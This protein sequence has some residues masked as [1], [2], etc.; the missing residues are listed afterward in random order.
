MGNT[1]TP[2]N[3][4]IIAAYKAADKKCKSLLVNLYGK[5]M[6]TE[7]AAPIGKGISTFEQVCAALKVSARSYAIPAKGSYQQKADAAMRRLKLIA[8]CF[9]DGWVADMADTNQYKYWAWFDIIKDASKLAGFGFSNA[10][11]YC[12][13]TYAYVGSRPNFKS[14][15]ICIYVGKAFVSEF[16][17]FAQ[18]QQLA[19]NEI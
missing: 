7:K 4:E 1:K 8:K 13:F 12:V 2:D 10:N 16:E 6:F 9:N 11:Y 14:S 3:Q 18:F 15:E 5:E 17:R 19:D